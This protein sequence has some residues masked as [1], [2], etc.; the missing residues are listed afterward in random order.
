MDYAI[1]G[2]LLLNIV[3]MILLVIKTNSSDSNYDKILR[4]EM[5]RNRQE[6]KTS[7]KVLREEL[8]NAFSRQST[9]IE[10]S[11]E[12]FRLSLNDMIKDNRQQSSENRTMIDSKL[13]KMR[14][15]VEEKLQTTLQ[16][17]IGEA[18]TRV[19]QQLERVQKD[20]GKMQ[21]LADGVGDLKRVLTNVKERGTWGEV[22]LGS[23]LEQI[24]TPEQFEENVQVK[25][26]SQERVDYA[27]KLPG[28]S[29]EV[30]WLP[31]DAKFPQESYLRILQVSKDGDKSEVDKAVAELIKVV[32]KSAADIRDKYINPPVTTD[33]AIMF[34]PTEGLYSEVLRVPGVMESMQQK[35]RIVIAGPTT[36]SAIMN[37]LRMGFKTLAIE[38]KASEVWKYLSAVKTQFRL[39]GEVMERL[40]DQVSKV[41]RTL[42]KTSDRAR[43]MDS[44]L[45]SLEKITDSEADDI[46]GIESSIDEEE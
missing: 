36:L 28:S 40:K 12:R 43:I 8:M 44:R 24:L 29:D 15:T 3:I 42:D 23:I 32:Q 11:L 9:L 2:L 16:K 30:L 38:K 7:E 39:F 27:V 37:S 1:I 20:L 5:Q 25:K 19:E 31:I 34:L 14:E 10:N 35:Y 46:L 21:T 45:R 26:N 13:E 17:R 22:K 33:F 18:F 4:D 6:G 41:S